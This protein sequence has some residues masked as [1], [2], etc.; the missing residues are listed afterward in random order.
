MKTE[1]KIKIIVFSN[2][3]VCVKCIEACNNVVGLSLEKSGWLTNKFSPVVNI[4][5]KEGKKKEEKK[6]EETTATG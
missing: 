3:D 2:Q 1:I 5:S 6:E 4:S